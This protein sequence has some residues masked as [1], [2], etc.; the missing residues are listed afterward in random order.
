MQAEMIMNN[1][2]AVVESLQ[3]EDQPQELR[4][5]RMTT[6]GTAAMPDTSTLNGSMPVSPSN[7][8]PQTEPRNQFASPERGDVPMM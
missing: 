8:A 2:D 4:S 3:A 5:P 6:S 1:A 7:R